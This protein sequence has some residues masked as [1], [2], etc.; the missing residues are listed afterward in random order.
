MKAKKDTVSTTVQ[1]P[2]SLHKKIRKK[3]QEF[4]EADQ[5]LTIPEV[6]VLAIDKGIDHV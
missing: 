6:I 1:Y 5:D 4:Y 3:Q 2:K